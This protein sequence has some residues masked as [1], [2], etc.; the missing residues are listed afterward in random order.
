MIENNFAKRHIQNALDEVEPYSDMFILL[1]ELNRTIISGTIRVIESKLHNLG[2]PKRMISRTKLIG[3]EILDNMQKHGCKEASISSYF[4]VSLNNSVLKITAGNCVS[5]TDS[6]FLTCT[7]NKYNAMSVDGIKKKYLEQLKHGVL[8]ET[9]NA[10]LGLL[11]IL[12]RSEKKI[13]FEMEKIK[14]DEFYFNS[15][16]ILDNFN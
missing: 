16:V 9:G 3:V 13:N 15:N 6:E 14:E 5:K 10:G 8:S 2:Y 11:S 12:K 7:L 1:G 4:E